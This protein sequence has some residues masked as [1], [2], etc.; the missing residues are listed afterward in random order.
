MPARVRLGLLLADIDLDDGSRL[1]GLYFSTSSSSNPS[2]LFVNPAAYT[3]RI[4]GIA[5]GTATVTATFS[6]LSSTVQSRVD[7]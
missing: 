3:G 5:P 7:P 4:R 1:T 6:G 2:V